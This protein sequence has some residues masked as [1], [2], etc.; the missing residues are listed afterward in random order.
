MPVYAH[1][2]VHK[3]VTLIAIANA[4]VTDGAVGRYEGR[5]QDGKKHGTG[6]SKWA[7]GNM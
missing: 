5:Y 3:G 4:V 2:R 6:I 1:A 7:N